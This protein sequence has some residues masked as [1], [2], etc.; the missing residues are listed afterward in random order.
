VTTDGA[1]SMFGKKAGFVTLFTKYFGH[2]LLGFQYSLHEKA[3]C[4]KGGLEEFE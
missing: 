4:E 1:F 2:S 3:L